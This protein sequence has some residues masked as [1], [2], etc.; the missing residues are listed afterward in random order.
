MFSFKITNT[1]FGLFLVVQEPL[2]DPNN[3]MQPNKLLAQG[4]CSLAI[5]SSTLHSIETQ[6]PDDDEEI[7]KKFRKMLQDKNLAEVRYFTI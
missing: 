5:S 4:N 2:I 7:D 1:I 6:L 3:H